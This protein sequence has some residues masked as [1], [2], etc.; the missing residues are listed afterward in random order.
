[1]RGEVRRHGGRIRATQNQSAAS[2]WRDQQQPTSCTT[3]QAQAS[4]PVYPAQ[5]L[6][7][8]SPAHDARGW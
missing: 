5:G 2:W 4:V 3:V 8:S 7:V 6:N 1:M